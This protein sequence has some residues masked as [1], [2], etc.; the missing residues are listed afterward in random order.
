MGIY[1]ENKINS[2]YGKVGRSASDEVIFELI[3]SKCLPVLM[4][5]LDVCPSNSADRHSL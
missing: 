1:V 2:I 3:K 4:Y 5:G